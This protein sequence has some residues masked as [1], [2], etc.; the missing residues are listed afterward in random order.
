MGG[1]EKSQSE[2]NHNSNI[3]TSETIMKRMTGLL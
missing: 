2:V 3:N 1:K